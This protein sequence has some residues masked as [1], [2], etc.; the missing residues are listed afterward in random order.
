MLQ[1]LGLEANPILGILAC[2][3]SFVMSLNLLTTLGSIGVGSLIGVLISAY[4]QSKLEKYKVLFNARVQAYTGITGRV[5]NLFQELD[6]HSL[7]DEVKFTKLNGLFSEVLLLGSHELVELIGEFKPLIF[8]FHTELTKIH[9]DKSYTDAK[10]KELNTQLVK[11]VG[12]IHTQMRKDLDID[13][14]AVF[15]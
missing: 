13:K 2:Y 15:N 1:W 7:P 6:I 8:E 14:N 10:A 3:Y 12:K 4:S 11:L 5:F 9:N